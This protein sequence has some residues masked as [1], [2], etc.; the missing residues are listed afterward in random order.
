MMVVPFWGKL[1]NS[2]LKL[3]IYAKP[4]VAVVLL[5]DV[6]VLNIIELLHKFQSQIPNFVKWDMTKKRVKHIKTSKYK[7][8]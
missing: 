3:K 4:F 5:K 2:E 6:L 1:S 8:K 7:I